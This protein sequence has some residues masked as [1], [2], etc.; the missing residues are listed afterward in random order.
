VSRHRVRTGETPSSIA[1]L[2][3]VPW[4]RIAA[5]NWGTTDQAA[6][7][8]HYR[9]TL[10]CTRRAPD[11]RGLRFDD[12]DDPGI[13][14]V[15]RPVEA[16]LPVGAVHRLLAAPRRTLFLSLENEAGLALPAASFHVRFA[17][18]SERRGALGG[19]GIA[20]LEGVPDQP[21]VVSYPDE[22][23]LLARSLAVSVRRAL[24]EQATG[25][26]FT[27]LMQS[28]EV[29]DRAVA[30]YDRHLDDLGGRGL[31]ADI[32]LVVTDPEARRPLRALGALA[33][34]AI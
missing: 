16:R 20:R 14:L 11:G 5:F 18:G 32:D 9:A 34:L 6:L 30:I 22:V 27:L 28:Q 13:L 4:D 25:P 7:E 21:F 29:V 3:G 15:P 8:A 23:D 19:R 17:D 26:L 1:S 31:A 24:D 2:H 33:G 12:G 10:G